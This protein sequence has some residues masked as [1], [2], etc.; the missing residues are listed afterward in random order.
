MDDGVFGHVLHAAIVDIL[1]RLVAGHRSGLL[2]PWLPVPVIIVPLILIL[3]IIVE[4]TSGGGVVASA[5][6]VTICLL[7]EEEVS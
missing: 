5:Y 2:C 3:L 7:N 4:R 6:A 1:G